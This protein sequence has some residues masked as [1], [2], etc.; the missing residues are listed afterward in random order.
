MNHNKENN[1][2]SKPTRTDIDVRM[3]R[4]VQYNKY[5]TLGGKH[6]MQNANNV[7]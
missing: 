7:L 4:Q 3:S 1:H 6:I 2:R 5:F